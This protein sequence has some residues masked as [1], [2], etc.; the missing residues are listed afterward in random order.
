M[1]RR[2]RALKREKFASLPYYGARFLI[3]LFLLYASR[4]MIEKL[5]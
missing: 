4:L 2:L 1:E 5:D 3:F